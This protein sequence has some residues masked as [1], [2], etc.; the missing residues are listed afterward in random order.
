VDLSTLFNK[1]GDKVQSKSMK[2]KFQIF[3]EKRWLDVANINYDG[4]WFAT[5]VFSCKLLRKCHK[6]EVFAAIIIVVEKC[7]IRKWDTTN[8]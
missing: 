6:D 5:Q 2:E 8:V 7:N 3:M 4:V 1:E